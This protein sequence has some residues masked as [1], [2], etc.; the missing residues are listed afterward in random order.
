MATA[1]VPGTRSR[2]LS[3]SRP[4]SLYVVTDNDDNATAAMPNNT[5]DDGGTQACS[6][7]GRPAFPVVHLA[8]PSAPLAWLHRR[9]LADP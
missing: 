8:P 4:S 2:L 7:Q 1:L 5:K 6:S 3:S 9:N